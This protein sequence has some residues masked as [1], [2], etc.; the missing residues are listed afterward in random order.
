M[1]TNSVLPL[2]AFYGK[3]FANPL[4]LDVTGTRVAFSE[5]EQRIL[6]SMLDII[7]TDI[8][9]RPHLRRSGVPYGTR[10]RGALWSPPDVVKGVVRFET[11]RALTLWE[12]RIIVESVHAEE[13]QRENGSS[14]IIGD[15]LFRF[16]STN[17]PDNLVIPFTLKGKKL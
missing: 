16:R 2:P 17:R 5:G 12:P 7:L 4:R 8:T 10:I 1:S 6:D 3:G 13:V 11:E 14:A 9:E 15:V